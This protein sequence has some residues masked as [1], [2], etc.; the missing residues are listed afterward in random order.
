MSHAVVIHHR[1]GGFVARCACGWRGPS[2]PTLQEASDTADHHQEAPL[3]E[4]AEMVLAYL[5]EHGGWCTARELRER[6]WRHA[7]QAPS[8]GAVVA[9]LRRL[10]ARGWVVRRPGAGTT[11]TYSAHPGR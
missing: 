2:A 6:T 9:A 8:V 7:G 3:G 1:G 10:V 11:Y 5:V 4:T